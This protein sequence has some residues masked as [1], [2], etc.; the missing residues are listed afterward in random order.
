[1]KNLPEASEGILR[2]FR[3]FCHPDFQEEFEGDLL[4][5]FHQKAVASG[6]RNA[7][8]NL[9]WDVLTLC[10]PSLIRPFHPVNHFIMLRQNFK[11]SWRTLL[12]H[13]GF[14]LI[15]ITGLAL[16]MTIALLIG[17]W[18]ADELQFNRQFEHRDEIARVMQHR[19]FGGVKQTWTSTMY[20]LAEELRTSYGHLFKTVVKTT[21]PHQQ[22][23]KIAEDSFNETGLFAEPGFTAMLSL[24][25]LK[26]SAESIKE[27]STILLSETF[28]SNLF[29][30]QNPLNQTL[31]IAET[32]VKVGG[33]YQD[34]SQQSSYFNTHYLGNWLLYEQIDEWVTSME[35]PWRPNAF[36]TL[37][38]LAEN[39]PLETASTAIHTIIADHTTHIGAVAASEPIT[40]L[41]PMNKWYLESRFEDGINT[42]GR[43]DDVWLFG[44][45]GAFILLLACINFMNLSTARSEGRA[46]EVGVRKVLGSARSQLMGQFYSESIL[47]SA[48]AFL[49]ALGFTLLV[50]SAISLKPAKASK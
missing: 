42:G 13:K 26:G 3:W 14:S 11:I 31:T 32:A 21:H 5:R 39:T 27:P 16:G 50:L 28:A 35:T 43:I 22:T 19:T 12:K 18:L 34:F 9:F 46:K 17:M 15:N 38:Q 37:I 6:E 20:P 36:Q 1:M 48:L 40:F 4:E 10:R 30:E 44:I 49:L 7:Q 45:V 41:H 23:F 29:G 33:I 8:W 25:M 2:F 24:K 47:L